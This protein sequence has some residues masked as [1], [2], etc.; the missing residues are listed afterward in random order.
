MVGLRNRAWTT[1]VV[2]LVL[3]LAAASGATVPL[4]ADA[5]RSSA[6]LPRVM[7][8]PDGDP[9]GQDAFTAPQSARHHMDTAHFRLHWTSQTDDV[10]Q[11]AFLK[12]AAAVFEDVWRVQIDQLAW[13][14][15][16]PDGVLGGN[17]K[18][19]V[20][21]VDLDAGAYGYAAA[22]DQSLCTACQDAYGY[23]VMDNDYAGFAPDWMGALRSTAAHE[24]SHLVQF[25]IAYD[26]EGWAYEAT[27]VWLEQRVYPDVDTRSQYLADFVADPGLPLTDF[28]Y[29]RGGFDRSYGAYVWNVWL[30]QRFGPAV[31]R[32]AWTA[33]ATAS[34]HMLKGYDLALRRR[35]TSLHEELVAFV[36]A[37]AAWDTGGF[38]SDADRYPRVKR[39]SELERGTSL[40]IQVDHSAAFLADLTVAGDVTLSV[41]G[42]K[43]VAGGVALVAASGSHVRTVIDDTLFDGSA[44]VTLTQV[45]AS[46]RVTVVVVNADAT[47]AE[48]K[49]SGSDLAR[50]LFDDVDYRVGIDVDPGRLTKR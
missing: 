29:A 46:T 40:E 18:I 5:N 23:L 17:D 33:A 36:A 44:T 13:P 45:D 19:D 30:S 37:T 43:F 16:A 41:R 38:P 31:V 50:Y 12:Q 48:P 15:P 32:D 24:F 9:N 8:R 2:A 47:L 35:G 1:A 7:A 34:D 4:T 20:Y 6:P 3:T 25:G 14:P 11:P 27:A 28:S 21:F 49:Q 39:Q 42:P 26:A 22:D 10:T